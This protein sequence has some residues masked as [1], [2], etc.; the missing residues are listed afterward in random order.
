MS[1]YYYVGATHGDLQVTVQT[2][3][4]GQSAVVWKPSAQLQKD[5][6]LRE[7]IQFSRNHSFQ[8]CNNIITVLTLTASHILAQGITNDLSYISI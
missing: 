8:V 6:W 2:H 5:T 3:P 1:F 7:V 4:A